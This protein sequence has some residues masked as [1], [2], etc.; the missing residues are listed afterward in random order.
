MLRDTFDVIYGADI[1]VQGGTNAALS[2]QVEYLSRRGYSVGILPMHL[3]HALGSKPVYERIRASVNAGMARI[4]DPA[5]AHLRCDLFIIDNPSL[6]HTARAE[7]PQV[8]VE[9]RERVIIAPFP[10]KDGRGTTYDPA[11]VQ[12]EAQ[13]YSPGPYK[14]AP[15]APLV[16]NQLAKMYPFL[17]MTALAPVPIVD[18]A[19]Y[20]RRKRAFGARAVIGRH[21]RPQREKW[22]KTRKVF[23][24]AYPASRSFDI[25]FLGISGPEL[26]EIIGEVPANVTASGYNSMSVRDFL[27][28][29][30]VFVYF[31]HPNWV[32]ALGIVVIEAMLSKIPCVLPRYMEE[33]FGPHAIYADEAGWAREYAR[34]RRTPGRLEQ[35]T[36]DAYTFARAN[37]G[38]GAFGRFLSELKVTPRQA[39]GEARVERA[40]VL[41]LMDR[42]PATIDALDRAAKDQEAGRKTAV[43]NTGTGMST[44][45]RSLLEGSGLALAEKVSADLCY[46]YNPFKL[47]TLGRLRAIAARKLHIRLRLPDL[48]DVNAKSVRMLD[49]CPGDP[50]W[51]PLDTASRIK[52]EKAHPN[53]VIRPTRLDAELSEGTRKASLARHRMAERVLLGVFMESGSPEPPLAAAKALKRNITIYGSKT[54]AENEFEFTGQNQD[55]VAWTSR[56]AELVV[57]QD[58][59]VDGV[60][61]RFAMALAEACGIPVRVHPIRKAMD[62]RQIVSGSRT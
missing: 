32:E 58:L 30:D 8:A 29:I 2:S 19:N 15:V 47:A 21:S 12:M 22:P 54:A 56:L 57:I 48:A 11:V 7:M 44:Y 53:A 3:P 62:W 6:M 59:G 18:A 41:D 61:A 27:N 42:S 38:A 28:G 10:A 50:V 31:H 25:R 55:I 17:E 37:Y 5:T 16:R 20:A 33:N 13:R 9:S 49:A 35:L 46:L 52:L 45:A 26:S 60:G 36:E 43:V 51:E 4:V 23:L 34:W 40:Y 24:Q 39:Q 1:Y 14:W